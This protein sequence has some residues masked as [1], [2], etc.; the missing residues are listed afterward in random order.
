MKQY[1]VPLTLTTLLLAPGCASIVSKSSYSVMINSEPDDANITI[2]D[3]NG[4]PVFA[5]RTPATAFLSSRGRFF[6]K[7]SY[8][9]KFSKDGYDDVIL[10]IHFK[11]DG[12]YFGNFVFGGLLG[13]L[14]IYPAT[15]AMY[16]LDTEVVHGT[17]RQTVVHSNEQELRLYSL[18]EIPS[19]WKE[20]LVLLT[21]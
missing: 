4:R 19:D 17:L 6:K 5:G 1:I 2:T 10:P 11:L 21:K 8:S 16:K 20:H 18:N 15:G 3:L 9:V 13:L 7:A 14:I 12:W